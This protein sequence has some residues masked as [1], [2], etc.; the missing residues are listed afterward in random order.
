MCILHGESTS[1]SSDFPLLVFA[2]YTSPVRRHDKPDSI[3]YQLYDVDLHTPLG[4]P[5]RFLPFS[6]GE[7]KKFSSNDQHELENCRNR[8][9][10]DRSREPSLANGLG[11]TALEFGDFWEDTRNTPRC[12]GEHIFALVFYQFFHSGVVPCDDPKCRARKASLAASAPLCKWPALRDFIL[13]ILSC[14]VPVS[15]LVEGIWDQICYDGIGIHER[16]EMPRICCL[17]L[18]GVLELCTWALRL[19]FGD[20]YSAHGTLASMSAVDLPDH[21][22][23]IL[24]VEY[25]ASAIE[26]TKK[27][28]E[29]GIC[30]NRLWNVS[31]QGEQG[32]ADISILANMAFSAPLLNSLGKHDYCTDQH[33]LLATH[34]STWVEQVHK[35]QEGHCEDEVRFPPRLL[36]EAFEKAGDINNTSPWFNTAWRRFVNL[37][38]PREK[39]SLCETNSRSYM[40]ISHVWADGTGVGKKPSRVNGCLYKYFVSIATRL[41]CDG[42]WWDAVSIPTD[43]AARTAAI[44][45]MLRN[46]EMAKITLVH[47]EDLVRFPW[48][49]D[50]TP[51]VALVLSTWFTRSWTAAELWASRNHPVKV[52]FADPERPS[53]PPLIKDLDDDILSWDLKDWLRP[54][55][56]KHRG[57]KKRVLNPVGRIPLPG[58]F[59]ASDIIRR[60][61][62]RKHVT[63]V[64]DNISN[65]LSHFLIGLRSRTT[66]WPR[67]RMISAGLIC[68]PPDKFESTM[69]TPEITRKILTQMDIVPI[70]SLFHS[71]IPVAPVGGWDWCPQSIYDFGHYFLSSAPD[72]LCDITEDGRMQARFTAWEVSEGDDIVPCGLH[73]AQAARVSTALSN[74]KTCLLLTVAP[75]QERRLYILFQPIHVGERRISGNWVACVH[76]RKYHTYEFG[77][78]VNKAGIPLPA[79][80]IETT[81]LAVNGFKQS[82]FEGEKRRWYMTADSEDGQNARELLPEPIQIYDFDMNPA[83]KHT[84]YKKPQEVHSCTTIIFQLETAESKITKSFLQT[85]CDV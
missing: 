3:N 19:A 17:E 33:C 53:G 64:H 27:C 24:K 31:L 48:R 45:A 76:L 67:D 34:P 83:M 37:I 38:T 62:V 29:Y 80:S 51:A 10:R 1:N 59:V 11:A 84:T 44:N 49:D 70:V 71:E 82:I 56:T 85:L 78:N 30:P 28:R 42:L 55:D 81:I 25:E 72:H 18:R 46:Y 16:P 75:L 4:T 54:A 5:S 63:T 12:L 69:T 74:R 14:W 68:L 13:T 66:S 6:V 77:H 22:V 32:P 2:Q 79:T 39:Q 60:F 65:S 23:Q 40:A 61:R 52:L 73:P 41:E 35:C 7:P 47:D 26:H 21:L 9:Y 8:D 58:H 36:N 43:R 57:H 50:G 20:A 15:E